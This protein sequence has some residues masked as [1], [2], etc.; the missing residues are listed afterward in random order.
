[1]E[2]IK[3]V[4]VVGPCESD[5]LPLTTSLQ[6]IVKLCVFVGGLVCNTQFFF[7][8]LKRWDIVLWNLTNLVT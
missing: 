2:I 7:F 4:P 3:A 1:V 8:F 6:Q 5:C